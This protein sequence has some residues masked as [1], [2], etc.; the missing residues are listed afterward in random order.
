MQLEITLR[1]KHKKYQFW[2]LKDLKIYSGTKKTASKK[3]GPNM[4]TLKL[5]LFIN[6]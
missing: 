1:E 3:S 6:P 2:L 5:I 4:M